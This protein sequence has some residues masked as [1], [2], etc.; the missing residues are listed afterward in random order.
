MYRQRIR[1][2][3]LYGQ[4]CEYIQIAEEVVALSK[5]GGGTPRGARESRLRWAPLLTPCACSCA[6]A[7]GTG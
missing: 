6:K 4:F 5:R 3:I 7:P 2:Q 1:Q